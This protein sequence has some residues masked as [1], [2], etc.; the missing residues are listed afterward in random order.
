MADIPAL[1]EKKTMYK[2]VKA[3]QLTFEGFNQ[4]GYLAAELAKR[5]DRRCAARRLVRIGSPARQG[6][7]DE[8]ARREN[9]RGTF[10]APDPAGV[11]GRTVLLV[12]D[13]MTT[14][15]TFSE[16]AATLKAAGAARVWCLALARSVRN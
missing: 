14:G 15:A 11:C 8:D 16:A 1:R 10:A 7:L 2:A 3:Q 4:C 9:V 5:I 6:G 13:I 12:D